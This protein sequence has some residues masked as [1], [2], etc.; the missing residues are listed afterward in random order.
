MPSF[1]RRQ[2]LTGFDDKA[3]VRST[4]ITALMPTFA[5][6]GFATGQITEMTALPVS[7]SR[8][9]VKSTDTNTSFRHCICTGT[10]CALQATARAIAAIT[11]VVNTPGQNCFIKTL[12]KPPNFM[13]P[14]DLN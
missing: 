2:A 11:L 9:S 14:R 4:Q 6:V 1:I 5:Y 3:V 7:I 8:L 13:T 10:F 12:H